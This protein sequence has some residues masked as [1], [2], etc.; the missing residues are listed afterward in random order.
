MKS[1][2]FGFGK[3]FGSGAAPSVALNRRGNVVMVNEASNGEKHYRVGH[4]SQATV[5]WGESK[6]AGSGLT[7]RVALNNSDVAVEVHTNES[8]EVLYCRVGR[9]VGDEVTWP[10]ARRYAIGKNHVRPV[11]AV[12]DLGVVVE[13]HEVHD[14][15]GIRPDYGVGQ[16]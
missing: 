10:H 14:R 7:P 5:N 13:V 4:L 1:V 15:K 12:N 3:P 8:D 6:P 2:H 11:V 9:L 16:V